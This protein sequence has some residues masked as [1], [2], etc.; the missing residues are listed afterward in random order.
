M[1]KL[2]VLFI[3]VLLAFCLTPAVF[4][5]WTPDDGH[6]MHYPQYPDL[7]G[8][9][10]N[11]TNP[12]ILADDWMC[13][14]SG[15]VSEIHFWGSWRQGLTGEIISFNLSI[16]ADI[17]ADPPLI[18]YSRPGITLWEEEVP[19]T[20]VIAVSNMTDLDEGWYNP[21]QGFHIHP[22]HLEYWQYNVFLSDFLPPTEI[23]EQVEGTIYWLNIS[24]TIIDPISTQWGWK[25]SQDH[26]NDDA[27]WAEWFVLDWIDLFVPPDFMES[28]DLAFVINGPDEDGACCYPDPTGPIMLCIQT[29]SVDC[30]NNLLG[31]Y[32]G[33]G[34]I[35]QGMQACCLPNGSCVMAD[36]LCCLNELG[37]IPQGAGTAC[38]PLE[39][40]CFPDNSCM[41]LDPLCCV[42]WGGTPQGPGSTCLGV[43]ACCLPDGSCITV[44]AM[45][46]LALGGN[47]QGAGTFCT[48]PEACCFPDGTCADL[49]PLCCNDLGGNSQGA[50]TACSAATIACCLTDG[51]CVDV[52][53]LCCD[54]LGGTVGPF[55]GFCL[56]DSDGD[57]NDDACVEPAETDTCEYYKAPYEDYA[58]NGMP[59]FN[60]KQ[61]TWYIG[62][63]PGQQWTHCGPVA[64]AN[65]LW[66]FDSKFEP[67]PLD[68]RPFWP[69]PGNP[70]ANDGYPLVYS[71][72][73][74]GGWDDHDTLNVM[75][76]IDS[77]AA[78]C[79]TNSMPGGGTFIHDLVNGAITWITNRGLA[80]NYTINLYAIGLDTLLPMADF[81]FIREQVMESQD[82]IL[83]LGFWEEIGTD[84]CERVGGHYVTIAGV[85]TDLVDSA[86]CI[87]DP[88]LD[89]NEGG[90]HAPSLHND[91]YYV[92]GPHGTIHHDR[93][94]VV[95][96]PCPPFGWPQFGLELVNYGV[97]PG[98]VGNFYGQNLYDPTIDPI[99]PMGGP[100]HTILEYALIICPA[101]LTGACCYDAAG[102]KLCIM[103]DSID[104]E[105]N[106][107]GDYQ[108]DGSTCL[109]IEACCL[110]DG[111]CVMTD[112]LCCTD[113]G[114]T[115]QGS[116]S[117]CTALEGCCFADG[118]CVDLDPLCCLDQGGTPQGPT[119]SCSGT[120][121]ACCLQDGSCVMADAL[122]CL[123]MGGTPQAGAS[124]TAVEACCF[125]DGTCAMLD[126]VCCDDQGGT[127][128]GPGTVCTTPAACC[129]NDGTCITVDPLCCD[130]LGGTPQA[131]GG[132]CTTPEACCLP[133]GSCINVDP[134]C[135]LDQGG[136]PQG[137]GT[138][139]SSQTIACC[140]PNGTCRDVDPLC[141]DDIGGTP[142]T[143]ST[144]C[145][146]DNNGNLI[147]DACEPLQGACCLQDNTCIVTDEPDC[148]AQGGDYIGDGSVCLGDNDGDGIDDICDDWSNHKMHYPQLPDGNGWDVHATVPMYLADDWMCIESGPVKDIHFWGSWLD[149]M[150]G[151]LAGFH[152]SIFSDLP[153]N[154]PQVPY[155]QPAIELW[156]WDFDIDDVVINPLFPQYEEGWYDPEQGLVLPQNHQEFFRY[157]IYLEEQDW[158]IQEEGTVYWLAITAFVESSGA[159]WGWKSSFEHWNDDA[160]WGVFDPPMYS[161][162]EMYEPPF[163]EQSLDLSFVITNGSDCFGMCGDANGDGVVNVSDA[164]WIINYVFVGGGP[165]LPRLACGDANSDGMVNVSDAVW[166]INYVFVGGGPPG[167]CTPGSPV[168]LDGDCCPFVPP[169]KV[170]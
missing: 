26:W 43:E 67:A 162:V 49:D 52:D 81:N 160:V 20:H 82:V 136:T 47:P 64:L 102:L 114:G 61:D 56:G 117:T 94:D 74:S 72:D 112:A 73:A 168:W 122:C 31:V 148:T 22:D 101:E 124:C 3:G 40:C 127:P 137:S 90:A 32:Q 27:V 41:D 118:S 38:S 131:G 6:K 108:G 1:K 37:G 51:S 125:L 134:L 109:G 96:T 62:Q 123:N 95:P 2:F 19:Y 83:L 24:A 106:F 100:I 54:D 97:N 91:A 155:S 120:M 35:C 10:V 167:D 145:L 30:V 169:P 39:A 158:F 53:P 44:D 103:T 7:T 92:S 60:Q 139:C 156:A 84:L 58:P 110:P 8:Y 150:T 141:C 76:F 143:L 29:D 85:C 111:S 149:G 164:V 126:P 165:P 144:S 68:P 71:F 59:D 129:L 163:F 65:C 107:L 128:Q 135:C 79:L 13:S 45:C 119:T 121:L 146:G 153:A 28:L 48:A 69:G 70:A 15:P 166:I 147:D 152:I 77:L 86:I 33:D 140:L 157:D 105:N 113:M 116:A 16:H 78:Y 23:F 170:K 87:S 132:P 75:P 42:G 14:A 55:S 89:N 17:P 66:W 93:Y 5:D 142:S 133:S 130:D 80:A 36:A 154:P 4:A 57:G 104:C 88:F 12:I 34:S 63:P 161:W 46:C 11:A 138:S 159:R 151:E 21:M 18:P 99:P 25:N 50:G 115:P 98:N 9:N